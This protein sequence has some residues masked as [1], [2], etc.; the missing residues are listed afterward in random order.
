MSRG[1]E[2]LVIEPVAGTALAESKD[3]AKKVRQSV[4]LPALARGQR[5][6]LDFQRV[7][8]ATQSF[9]HAL[10]SD[11]IRRYGEEAFDLL[12]FKNCT[13]EVREIVMTV[14]EYTL[15][16]AEAAKGVGER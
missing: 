7:D 15:D 16:A 8:F 6:R 11:A 2:V 10:I 4:I 3:E 12:E 14:F 5:V 13:D 1:V 9:I